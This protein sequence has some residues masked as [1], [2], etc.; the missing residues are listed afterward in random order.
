MLNPIHQVYTGSDYN[1]SFGGGEQSHELNAVDSSLSKSANN[2]RI[3]FVG[4]SAA[5]GVGSGEEISQEVKAQIKETGDSY[6]DIIS[7]LEVS[8]SQNTVT[9]QN[10][11]SVSIIATLTSGMKANGFQIKAFSQTT[12]SGSVTGSYANVQTIVE[13][14]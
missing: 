8:K 1:S 13:I 9:G 4:T 2:V 7:Y 12:G 3:T 10:G 6:A 11:V 14:L 5:G